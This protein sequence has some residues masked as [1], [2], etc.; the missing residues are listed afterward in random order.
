M[1]NNVSA[2]KTPAPLG[3]S[4]RSVWSAKA[5]D[6]SLSSSGL[7]VAGATNSAADLKSYI[8]KL[9]ALVALLPDGETEH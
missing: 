5:L 7:S 6:F 4:E 3:E 1:S 9:E 2:E 8:A